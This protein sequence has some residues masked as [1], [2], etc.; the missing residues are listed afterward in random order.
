MW[1]NNKLIISLNKVIIKAE[2][3]GLP[4]TDLNVAKEY[5]DHNEF[6]L[7]LEHI[8]DQLFEF[9]IQINKEIYDA[10]VL[11]G[12]LMNMNETE[13]DTLKTLLP[14]QASPKL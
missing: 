2:Q 3:I 10:V 9:N 12:G 7:A 6:A 5:I 8:V 13:F 14:F 11:T 4:P 1:S